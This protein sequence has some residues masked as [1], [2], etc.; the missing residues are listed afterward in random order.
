MSDL[1]SFTLFPLLPLEIRLMIWEFTLFPRIFS[2]VP[3]GYNYT[4]DTLAVQWSLLISSRTEARPTRDRHEVVSARF[5]TSGILSHVALETSRESR[6]LV[7]SRGYRVW[8]MQN[9]QGHVRHVIWHPVVD[10]ILFPP[11][12][13][14][15]DPA[16]DL[17]VC[18]SKWL[19]LF[20]LQ[21]PEE[22][23]MA[24]NIAM[25]TS[26]AVRSRPWSGRWKWLNELAK[27]QSLRELVI[28]VDEEAE[29]SVVKWLIER[30]KSQRSDQI[31][32]WKIPQEIEEWLEKGKQVWPHILRVPVVRVVESAERVLDGQSLQICLRCN[33]CEY[34]RMG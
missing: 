12:P 7:F 20:S 17:E 26:M 19:K 14:Y 22:T 28:V 6:H 32:A 15:R 1:N 10:V 2:L 9:G 33:P 3:K 18:S 29:K 5:L 24:N 34:L 31:G 13:P 21:Y 4:E 27:F 30:K 8:K 16:P 25:Y 23:K 11:V